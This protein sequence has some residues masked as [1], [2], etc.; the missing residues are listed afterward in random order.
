MAEP[1]VEGADVFKGDPARH[2]LGPPEE[3]PARRHGPQ[4][5]KP[6]RTARGILADIKHRR[7]EL[8]PIVDEYH[9]LE[10]A[11]AAIKNI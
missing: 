7:E 9:K 5:P 3:Q 2:V 11:Y 10:R 4:P 8:A 6:P 1:P